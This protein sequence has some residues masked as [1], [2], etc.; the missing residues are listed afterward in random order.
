MAAKLYGQYSS[1]RELPRR[2]PEVD[3]FCRLN[4][5]LRNLMILQVGMDVGVKGYSDQGLGVMA[6]RRV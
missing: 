5:P 2:L 3:T 4:P 6:S 1:T